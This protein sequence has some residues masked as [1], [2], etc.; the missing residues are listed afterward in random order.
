MPP[1]GGIGIFKDRHGAGPHQLDQ[2][3][4]CAMKRKVRGFCSDSGCR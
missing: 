2:N 3:S 1:E 4:Y